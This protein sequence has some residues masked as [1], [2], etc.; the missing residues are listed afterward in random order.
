MLIAPLITHLKSGVAPASRRCDFWI[1]GCILI[2]FI[3]I[4]S[5]LADTKLTTQPSIEYLSDVRYRMVHTHQ[6][7]GQL[8]LNTCAF[9]RGKTRIPL[10]IGEKEYKKGLGHHAPGEIVIDLG[11][12]YERFEADVGLQP[13]G[14]G[15]GS[16]VSG[17][18]GIG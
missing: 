15:G 7:W 13:L 12:D 5:G 11:G 14:S 10:R 18:A 3:L 17:R 6:G 1:L 4:P 2:P 8:G 16:V 9:E